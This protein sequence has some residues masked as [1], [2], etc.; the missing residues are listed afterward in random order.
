MDRKKFI[1]IVSAGAVCG[2]FVPLLQ[3]CVTYRYVDGSMENDKLVVPK[4]AFQ[5]DDFVLVRNPQ[6]EAP[7]YLRKNSEDD[8]TALLLECTHRQCT[9]DPAGDRL[10]CPCH[11]SQYDGEGNVL[12]GPAREN[13]FRYKVETTDEEIFIQLPN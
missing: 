6:R 10:A 4:T 5:E 3:G 13:L 11:G 8:V 12:E 2:G 9:V 7:I 1:K